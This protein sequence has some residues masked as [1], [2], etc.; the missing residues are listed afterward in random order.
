[1]WTYWRQ[2]WKGDLSGRLVTFK[3]SVVNY[4]TSKLEEMMSWEGAAG[5]MRG[6]SISQEG[7]WVGRGWGGCVGRWEGGRDSFS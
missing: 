7:W 2:E 3:N 1:M 5:G 4:G 6:V